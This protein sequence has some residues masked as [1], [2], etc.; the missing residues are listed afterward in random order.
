MKQQLNNI[1]DDFGLLLIFEIFE[2]LIDA[3]NLKV[4]G[5]ILVVTNF[6]ELSQYLFLV[7]AY[8]VNVECSLPSTCLSSAL[9]R[10]ASSSIKG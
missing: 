1:A 2:I 10:G 4:I 3:R 9:I 8:L 7:I 5:E 6:P